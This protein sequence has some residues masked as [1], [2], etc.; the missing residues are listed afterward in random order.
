M[1]EISAEPSQC[2]RSLQ[3]KSED[4][5]R[6][7]REIQDLPLWATDHARGAKQK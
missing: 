5:E 1:I 3:R 6:E 4:L 7:C 2:Y